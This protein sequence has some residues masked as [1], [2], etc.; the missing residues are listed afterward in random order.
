VSFKHNANSVADHRAMLL[1]LMR[2]RAHHSAA[3]LWKRLS[4]TEKV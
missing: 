1:H 4:G 3:W 2:G